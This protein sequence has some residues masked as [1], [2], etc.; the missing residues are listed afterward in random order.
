MTFCYA[1][2]PA[3]RRRLS[4]V[5]LFAHDLLMT[6]LGPF[7][8]FGSSSATVLSTMEI[9]ILLLPSMQLLTEH[10]CMLMFRVWQHLGTCVLQF[11]HWL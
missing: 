3:H 2:G 4:S 7:T 5:P 11:L 1:V 8:K 10:L 9:V 6:E